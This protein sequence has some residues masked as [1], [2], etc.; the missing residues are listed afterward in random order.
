MKYFLIAL[1]LVTLPSC[2]MLEQ[3]EFMHTETVTPALSG[4]V[5]SGSFISLYNGILDV[6]I[7]VIVI[8]VDNCVYSKSQIFTTVLT[9]DEC[10]FNIY[11]ETKSKDMSNYRIVFSYTRN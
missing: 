8:T 5:A 11:I 6:Y 10:Q 9:D 3:P 4:V 7:S 2:W 1:I